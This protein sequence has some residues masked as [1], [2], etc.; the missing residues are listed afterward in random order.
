MLRTNLLDT[1]RNAPGLLGPGVF[2]V[3]R[4][5]VR[6]AVVVAMSVVFLLGR[7]VDDRRL[8]GI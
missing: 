8:G 4:L 5:L 7:L 6:V 1:K 3:I 2:G